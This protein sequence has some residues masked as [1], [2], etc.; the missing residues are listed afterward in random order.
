MKRLVSMLLLTAVLLCG[1]AAPA[2]QEP[3]IPAEQNNAVMESVTPEDTY[4]P[5]VEASDEAIAAPLE[6][7]ITTTEPEKQP[8]EALEET[9]QAKQEEK[10]VDKDEDIPSETTKAERP[11]EKPENEPAEPPAP[12]PEPTPAPE[13]PSTPPPEELTTS[14]TCTFSIDCLT[15]LDNWEDLKSSKV[16]VVPSD[17]VI[18]SAVTATFSE[19][20]SVFDVLQRVCRDNGVSLEAEWTPGYNTAYIEGIGN[21]YERDCG[22]VSGWMYSVNGQFPG[23]GCSAYQLAEGDSVAFRYTCNLGQDIGGG[24]TG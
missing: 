23:I 7:A 11:A 5:P 2:K 14:Y 20:E 4:T 13:E 9:P 16:D 6:V 10:P 24:V 19:G 1:C 22:P 15:V 12:A 3:V 18:L 21:L 8:E 17:G